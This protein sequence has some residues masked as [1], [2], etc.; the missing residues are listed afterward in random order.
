MADAKKE[1]GDE[2]EAL[3]SA[4]SLHKAS[5]IGF[6]LFALYAL[7]RLSC[8]AVDYGKYVASL[9]ENGQQQ[10]MA[11]QTLRGQ[12]QLEEQLRR[13]GPVELD[14]NDTI[15][16]FLREGQTPDDL[17]DYMD[18]KQKNPRSGRKPQELDAE[19]LLLAAKELRFEVDPQ[20]S[21]PG[22]EASKK[23]I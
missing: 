11:E 7:T 10:G 3:K 20:K 19:A 21:D 23:E 13:S 12:S 4:V 1:K 8:D 15:A 14:S 2:A 9:A 17:G 18:F 5:R 16:D 22:A 6:A